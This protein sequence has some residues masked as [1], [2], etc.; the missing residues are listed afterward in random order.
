[1][2][3]RHRRLGYERLLSVCCPVPPHSAEVVENATPSGRVAWYASAVL[4]R[5]VPLPLFGSLHNRRVVL[6]GVRRLICARRYEQCSMHDMMQGFRVR[7][8]VWAHARSPRARMQRANAAEHGKRTELVY[9]WVFWLVEEVVIP[10]LRTTFYATETHATRLRVVY[11]RQDVWDALCRPHYEQL[12]TSVYVPHAGDVATASRVRLVPKGASMRP[13]TNLRR[14]GAASNHKMQLSFDVLNHVRRTEPHVWGATVGDAQGVFERLRHAKEVLSRDGALPRLY[15]VKSDVRAAFDSLDHETLIAVLRDVLGA[16]PC[17]LVVQRYAALRPTLESVRRDV[18][19]HSV[20]DNA[21]P[22]FPEVAAREARRTPHAVFVDSVAYAL[23]DA[24]RALYQLTHHVRSHDVLLG[25]DVHRQVVGVPQGSIVATMLCNLML[26]DAERTYLAP[27]LAHGH[28]LRW[29]DDFLYVTASRAHAEAFCD[30]L[31]RGFARHGCRVA[32]DKTLVNF[33]VVLPS[34]DVVHALPPGARMPWCGYAI[35]PD[36]LSVR[37]DASRIPT[38]MRDSLTVGS[39]SN[40]G[41]VLLA[42]VLTAVRQRVH[43]LFTDTV[44]NPVDVAYAN[45][46]DCFALAATR[47]HAHAHALRGV[48][49]V[50][51]VHVAR[52]A[53][54]SAYP[55]MAAHA[56]ATHR[57]T[58][59]CVLQRTHVEWL[60]WYAFWVVSRRWH[61]HELTRAAHGAVMSARLVRARTRLGAL[62]TSAWR[63]IRTEC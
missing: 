41:R 34:G 14:A 40:P 61:A 60:G 29:T 7:D 46:F 43:A 33:D 4:R 16:A 49:A 44:L 28:L 27:A 51:L 31:A 36:D 37:L 6:L 17:E 5:L 56:R 18:V 25:R 52:S 30:A 13:I 53:I 63:R 8:C 42:R 23:A 54:N 24:E 20:P 15:L 12:G 32:L 2:L 58:V 50:F 48:R 21:Y 47:M 55:I 3:R 35:S 38:R 26:A 39:H 10:L 19:R 62:A 11:F 22:C 1:M 45:V 57:P 59:S 9:A